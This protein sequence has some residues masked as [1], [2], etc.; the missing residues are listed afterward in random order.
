MA[1]SAIMPISTAAG[2]G[3]ETLFSGGNMGWDIRNITF[4]SSTAVHAVTFTHSLSRTPQGYLNI[5]YN[6]F[7]I[8][9]APASTGQWNASQVIFGVAGDTVTNSYRILLM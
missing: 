9:L 7:Q 8:A 2:T 4:A 3:T 5:L 1:A 6:P